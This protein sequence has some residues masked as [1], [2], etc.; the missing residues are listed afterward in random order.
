MT[1]ISTALLRFW[2]RPFIRLEQSCQLRLFQNH[3][4]GQAPGIA[5]PLILEINPMLSGIGMPKGVPEHRKI[6]TLRAKPNDMPD[7]DPVGITALKSVGDPQRVALAC[8]P[9]KQKV[10]I[11]AAG[12]QLIPNERGN[13]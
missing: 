7:T 11:P 8:T 9:S 3:P 10:L 12:H 13:A 1:R 6:I 2:E 4:L 5:P